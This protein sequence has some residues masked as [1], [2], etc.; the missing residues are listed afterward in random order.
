MEITDVLP[1]RMVDVARVQ[2]VIWKGSK[3]R[4]IGRSYKPFYNGENSKINC[5]GIILRED[6]MD[7]ALEFSRPNDRI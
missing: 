6:R 5:V 7:D 1:R 4:S 3:A 2:E